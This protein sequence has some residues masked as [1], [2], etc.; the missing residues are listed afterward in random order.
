MFGE[1]YVFRGEFAQ[2]FFFI[3]FAEKV[4]AFIGEGKAVV[5]LKGV[6]FVPGAAAGID[7]LQE[8]VFCWEAKGGEVEVAVVD[9]GKGF[10]DVGV[11]VGA[12]GDKDGISLPHRE[13]EE[14]QLDFFHR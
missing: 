10:L 12:G 3:G 2:V 7:F 14:N 5:R 13:G 1:G 8:A 9:F 6:F 11:G 4:F